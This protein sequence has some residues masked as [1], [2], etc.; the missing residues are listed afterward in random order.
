MASYPHRRATGRIGMQFQPPNVFQNVSR[1]YVRLQIHAVART[2]AR[3]RGGPKCGRYHRQTKRFAIRMGDGHAYTIDGYASFFN[4]E[5]AAFWRHR[6]ID[7]PVAGVRLHP[8]NLRGGIDVPLDKMSAQGFARPERTFQIHAGFRLQPAQRSA[9][10]GLGDNVKADH[11]RRHHLRNR[12]ADALHRDA[13]A[14]FRVH[15]LQFTKF[16]GKLPPEWRRLA[17]NHGSNAFHQAGKHVRIVYRHDWNGA[18]LNFPHRASA[19][20]GQPL[21]RCC[22]IRSALYFS[23]M[24]MRFHIDHQDSGTAARLGRITTPW[25]DFDT[26]AFMPVGTRGTVKGLTPDMIRQTG[27]QIILANTYHLMLRPGGQT[28][29]DLGGVQQFSGWRG[30]MLTDSGGFQVFSLSGLRDFGP[31]GVIFKS[32]IDGATVHLGP[33]QSMEIQ[34]QLGADIA[35]A[36]DDCPPADCP[37]DRLTAALE[38][39]IQWARVCRDVHDRLDADNRQALFGIVQGGTSGDQRRQCLA[40]LISI[41][42]DGYAIGGLAVGEGHQR[43][44]ETL[45]TVCGNMPADKPRYL[46]GVGYPRDIIAAVKR[47]VDMFDCVLPTRNGRNGLAFTSQGM[48]RLRNARYATD[49][50]PLDAA[51]DCLCCRGFSRGYLRHLFAVGEMLGPTLVSIHNVRFFQRL[52]LDIRAAIRDNNL[53]V[54]AGPDILTA[55]DNAEEST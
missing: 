48:C 25:G 22:S 1:Q 17:V 28:V 51:C 13:L 31:D 8:D 50:R 26:P 47:G 54:L 52:M 44:V 11:A 43:M 40:E 38:R 45:D 18:K 33:R 27:R 10:Q 5:F 36:F 34:Y 2:Q 41:G 15:R 30:P 9:V 29:A 42:F 3:E 4:N 23:T 55:V 20:A 49:R 12:Q 21:R 24:A 37:A 16:N 53:S 7:P 35:M 19:V 32:H 6:Q 46:M 14:N 39:T